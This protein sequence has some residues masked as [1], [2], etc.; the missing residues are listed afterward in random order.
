[1]GTQG[2]DLAIGLDPLATGDGTTGPVVETRGGG[3]AKV[4][5]DFDQPVL[6]A[7]NPFVSLTGNRTVAGI[8][9]PAEDFRGHIAGVQMLDPD[10]LEIRMNGLPNEATYRIG[11]AGA[12]VG[13]AG[14]SPPQGRTECP[15]R[16]LVGDVSGDGRV[17]M[18]DPLLAKRAIGVPA[19]NSPHLDLNQ[20]RG[21]INLSDA[22][23]ARARSGQQAIFPLPLPVCVYRILTINPDPCVGL[24]AGDTVCVDCPESLTCPGLDLVP[25]VFSI[26]AQNGTQG[27]GTWIR[28]TDECDI[29]PT[30]GK[31]GWRFVP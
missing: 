16:A 29:C 6:L 27:T 18:L 4:Q 28:L 10:T 12:V 9:Q 13:A 30:G 3:V 20:N 11:V 1:M 22:L 23:A 8:L 21:L 24:T 19:V 7:A 17:T 5:V 2:T 14:G 15:V 26:E 25:T 31:S